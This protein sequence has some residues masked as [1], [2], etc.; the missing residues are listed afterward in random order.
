MTQNN[1]IKAEDFL[2]FKKEFHI[3]G[4]Q[5]IYHAKLYIFV[6][7]EKGPID[8]CVGASGINWNCANQNTWPFYP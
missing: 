2:F 4:N 5:I 1:W 3:N 8:N 6:K 7:G